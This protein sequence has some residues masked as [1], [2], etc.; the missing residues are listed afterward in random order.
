MAKFAPL[1]G[2]RIY[3]SL[4]GFAGTAIPESPLGDN[5]E[6]YS[7]RAMAQDQVEVMAALGHDKFYAAGHDR[8]ARVLHR[9]CLD[10]P[11]KVLRAAILDIVPQHH[12]Y[13]HPTSH[14][15]RFRG[16]GSSSYSP[17]LFQSA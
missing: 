14:G 17:I 5:H 9:M 7:F 11:E 10:H 15:R 13:N 8:G 3:R 4:H 16:T 1:L 6:S 2:A 12:V